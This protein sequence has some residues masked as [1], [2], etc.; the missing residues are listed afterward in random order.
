LAILLDV[1][2]NHV[3]PEGN[4]LNEFGPYRS[5]RHATPW[6]ESLNFDGPRAKPVRE[7]V[8]SNVLYWMQEYHFDGLRLDAVHFMFD[9]SDLSIAQEIRQRFREFEKSIERRVHL[10]AETNIF[11]P[12]L[13]A[14]ANADPLNYDAIWS[15]CLMHSIYS[16]GDP[17]LRLSDRKYIGAADLAEALEHAYVFSAPQAFRMQPED[18]QRHHPAG[19]RKY[20][21]SLI[22]A[23]QTHD[24]VGNHPQGKRLGQLTSFHFQKSAAALILLYPSIPMMFMGEESASESP[25]PFFVDF[26]DSNLRSAVDQGR[27]NEYPH[28]DWSDSPLPS[29][30]IAFYSSK[31]NPAGQ[32]SE[33][34]SWYQ[35]LLSLRKRGIREGWLDVKYMTARHDR[36]H[37]VFQ[38]IYQTSEQRVVISARLAAPGA[39]RRIWKQACLVKVL[40][41]SQSV[42]FESADV[43]DE[44]ISLELADQHCCVWIEP[45]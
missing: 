24:S 26:E 15:D 35:Q 19:D 39:P 5:L 23:L 45:S 36:M 1:V 17:G 27:R 9:E 22:M 2:Y 43:H 42:N 21:Q 3:G 38:L 20:I 28:H 41:D 7:F 12:E 32:S 44:A 13:L 34:R 18:R 16:Q 14:D 11:D 30:P 37:D 40:L 6:G 10:I 4:Y 8:I 31:P 33:M 25:F 29:D